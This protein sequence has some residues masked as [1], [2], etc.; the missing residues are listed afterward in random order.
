MEMKRSIKSKTTGGERSDK[1]TRFEAVGEYVCQ[2]KTIRHN[3]ESDQYSESFFIDM[4]VISGPAS[5][6]EMKF[7]ALFLNPE[8][9]RESKN[10]K[11]QKT[12]GKQKKSWDLEALQVQLAAAL[13]YPESQVGELADLYPGDNGL[14]DA[15]TDADVL[16]HAKLGG[17]VDVT[18]TSTVS[19]RDGKL[20]H[21]PSL[22]PHNAK[23]AVAPA[24]P[25]VTPVAGVVLPDGFALHPS[26]KNYAF[27]GDEVVLVSELLKR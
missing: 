19:N 12:T 17:M 24:L 9:Y 18:V 27:K 16:R 14:V 13:G 3:P 15:F 8:K 10:V 4:E 26:D 20:Y 6:G 25:A 11:G 22:K 5:V 21:N 1:S 2:V 23:R 7:Y